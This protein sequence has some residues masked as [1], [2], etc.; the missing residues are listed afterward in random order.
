MSRPKTR[1]HE[2]GDQQVGHRVGH[3]DDAH[4]HAVHAAAGEAG[5][6][7]PDHADA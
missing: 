5:D 1:D 4:H 2:D 7:A 6:G 3:V